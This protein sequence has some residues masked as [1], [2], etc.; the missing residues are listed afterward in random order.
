MSFL[1]EAYVGIDVAKPRNAIA[2]TEAGRK[3]EIRYI[4]EI[5]AWPESVKRLVVKFAPKH[6]RL[7]RCY[8]AG[9]TG[10]VLHRLITDLG[11]SCAVVAP[12]LSPRKASNRVKTTGVTQPLSPICCELAS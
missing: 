7:H 11:H 4:G 12:S 9:P 2:I 10:Y 5:D 6:A 3:G 1:N 8:E